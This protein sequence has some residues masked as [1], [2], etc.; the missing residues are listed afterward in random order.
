MNIDRIA[1]LN[2]NSDDAQIVD[3]TSIFENDGARP[4]QK[5]H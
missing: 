5:V 3:S 1:S 4:R 2:S